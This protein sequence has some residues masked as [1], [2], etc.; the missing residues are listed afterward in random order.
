MSPCIQHPRPARRG[1]L[2]LMLMVCA[3]APAAWATESG[4]PATGTVEVRIVQHRFDPPALTVRV[5]SVVRWANHETRTS[6]SVLFTGPGGFESERLMPGDS[7]QRRFDTPGR[8][9]YTCGPH[10]DMLGVVEVLP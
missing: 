2:R 10:P 8:Y 9:P 1:A 5:G 3:L 4:P 7:W 6:H